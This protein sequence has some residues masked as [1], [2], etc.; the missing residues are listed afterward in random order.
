M[1][2][3]G[4]VWGLGEAWGQLVRAWGAPWGQLEGLWG[5]LG[6]MGQ[7]RDNCMGYRELWGQLGGL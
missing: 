4:V 2:G 5:Q 3:V 7:H 6:L 1:P